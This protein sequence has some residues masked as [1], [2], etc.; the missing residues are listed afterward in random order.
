MK[1]KVIAFDLET[2]I[3][4]RSKFSTEKISNTYINQQA[5][6]CKISNDSDDY[7]KL[8]VMMYQTSFV[9]S[10]INRIMV[11]SYQPY[12]SKEDYY[13]IF[14]MVL[15][16]CVDTYEC[17]TG[18]FQNY[19]SKMFSLAL[20]NERKQSFMKIT[21]K[22]SEVIKK[23]GFATNV[24]TSDIDISYGNEFGI[25]K[26]LM[27]TQMIKQLRS[28]PNGELLLYKYLN[29]DKPKTDKEVANKF[30]LTIDQVR[31]KIKNASNIF[32]KRNP[33]YLSDYFYDTCNEE[34]ICVSNVSY[35]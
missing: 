14:F 11:G 26:E 32:K 12:C 30:H 16:K 29:T 6:A 31:F 24:S 3:K 23:K 20:A 35:C 25:D 8:A 4:E 34:Y 28:I 33:S 21:G 2:L 22:T 1:E 10:K 15:Y 9:G 27:N 19:F 7:L 5:L 17:N 18:N 13:S